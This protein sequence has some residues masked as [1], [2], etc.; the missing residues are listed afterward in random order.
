MLVYKIKNI[1]NGD[2]LKQSNYPKYDYVTRDLNEAINEHRKMKYE[3]KNKY[4]DWK[5]V[6]V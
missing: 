1:K 5:V 6:E 4:N 2:Y 3:G